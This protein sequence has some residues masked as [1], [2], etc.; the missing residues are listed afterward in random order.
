MLAEKLRFP[1]VG[2]NFWVI[3]KL[4]ISLKFNKKNKIKK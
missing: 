4:F 2:L 3:I 1:M